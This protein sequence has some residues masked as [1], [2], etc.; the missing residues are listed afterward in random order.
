MDKKP[1]VE[2]LLRDIGKE[3]KEKYPENLLEKRREELQKEVKFWATYGITRGCFQKGLVIILL[4][5][6]ALVFLWLLEQG[7]F[8]P[9]IALFM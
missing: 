5:V 2:K 6:L 4:V 3:G 7:I 9:I 1:D 8:S